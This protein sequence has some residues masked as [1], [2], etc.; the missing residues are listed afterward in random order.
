MAFISISSLTTEST[1]VIGSSPKLLVLAGLLLIA[2]LLGNSAARAQEVWLVT[3]GSGPEVWELFGH[4]ALWLRDPA[5]GLDHTF[6]FGYFEIDR[7]GFHLDFARGIMPYFG[8][9]VHAESEFEFYR[10]RGRSI[11]AQRLALSAE[12]IQT[13]H[14]HLNQ[15]IFPQPKYYPYDYFDAN[16]STWLRD[17]LDQV[18]GGLLAEQLQAKPARLNFLD[19]TRRLTESRF[20]LHNGILTL[21]GPKVDRPRSAWDEAFLPEAL[22]DWLNRVQRSGQP[23]VIEQRLIAGGVHPEPNRLPGGVAWPNL[24]L[25]MLCFLALLTTTWQTSWWSSWLVRL[26]LLAAGLAGLAIAAMGLFSGHEVTRYNATLLLLNPAWLLFLIALP[27][28]V[29][30]GLWWLLGGLVLLGTVVLSWPGVWQDRLDLV[31]WFSPLCA[32]LLLALRHQSR[33]RRA[34]NGVQDRP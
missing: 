4:N 12:E 20:W 13:L 10:R 3:Y 32:G 6:S 22:A 19:H 23:L 28:P 30:Q 27:R 1:A 33:A 34:S 8:A 24:G 16:C 5:S 15:A 7:P 31:L 21:L 26:G 2:G 17:L 29:Y 14:G 11:H 9:M 25:G 18:S